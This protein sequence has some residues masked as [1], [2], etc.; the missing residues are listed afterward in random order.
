[1]SESEEEET[2][3]TKKKTK[4]GKRGTAHKQRAPGYFAKGR[5]NKKQKTVSSQ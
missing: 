3:K 2:P 1:M 4:R 5:P